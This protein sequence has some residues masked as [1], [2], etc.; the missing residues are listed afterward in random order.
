MTEDFQVSYAWCAVNF[1]K[2][3]SHSY[4]TYLSIYLSTTYL[5]RAGLDISTFRPSGHLCIYHRLSMSVVAL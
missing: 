4:D 1:V 3:Q 5:P 2:A